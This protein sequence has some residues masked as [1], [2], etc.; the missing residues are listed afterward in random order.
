MSNIKDI[1]FASKNFVPAVK[2]EHHINDIGKLANYIPT[3]KSIDIIRNFCINENGSNVIIGSYG[4]GKSHLMALLAS[5]MCG[6]YEIEDY[7]ELVNKIGNIDEE[8]AELLVERMK[9]KRKRLIVIPSYNAENFEQAIL[10]G[11]SEALKREG[12]DYI[13][14]ENSFV[15]AKEEIVN[16]KNN[17]PET[18]DEF[19]N[20]IEKEYFIKKNKFMHGIESF[21]REYYKNFLNVYPRVTSG[22]QFVHYD[23]QNIVETIKQINKE[24]NIYGYDGL[25]IIFDE[26]G[27]FLEGNIDQVNMTEVQ[28]VAE[29]AND[30]ENNISLYLITH[31]DLS[32][33]GSK[34]SDRIVMEWRKVEGRFRRFTL[35]QNPVDIYQIISNTIIKDEKKFNGFYDCYKE[36]FSHMQD[37]IMSISTFKELSEDEIEKYLI[38]GCF[39]LAPLSVFA[40]CKLTDKIAQNNRTLFT[41]LVSNDENSFGDFIE[42]SEGQFWIGGDRIYDYFERS[43]WGENKESNIYDIWKEVN[44]AINKVGNNEVNIKIIKAIGLIYIIND[45]DKMKPNEKYISLLLP[46]YDIETIKNG[47]KELVEKKIIFYR[48]IYGIYKFYEGSDLNIQSY[49]NKLIDENREAI[50]IIDVLNK[51]FLPSPL[52]PRRYNDEYCINRYFECFFIRTKDLNAEKIKSDLEDNFKDGM[53][54]YLIP[55]DQDVKKVLNGM[56]K[57]NALSNLIIL[58][59]RKA[60]NIEERVL[61]YWVILQLLMDEEFLEKEEFLKEELILYEEEMSKEINTILS[62]TFNNEFKNVYVIHEGKVLLE[63]NNRYTLQ[64]EASKIMEKHFSKTPKINNEMINKNN[65]TSTM[66]SVERKV[67]NRLWESHKSG[68]KFKFKKFNAEYTTARTVYINTQ[69][70][71]NGANYKVNINYMNLPEAHPIRAIFYEI[72][73]FLKDCRKEETSFFELYKVLKNKPYGLKDGVI[74]L[75]FGVAICDNLDNIYIKRNEIYEDIDGKLLVEMVSNPRKF[76]VSIDVW[77]K[78]KENYISEIEN[79]FKENIDYEYRS[80]NR[81]GALYKGIKRYYMGLPKFTR[82]TNYISQQSKSIRNIISNDYMDYKKLFF[83]ILPG[84]NSYDLTVKEIKYAKNELD[85]FIENFKFEYSK[86]IVYVFGG[87]EKDFKASI[88]NWSRELGPKVRNHVFDLKTNLFIKYIEAPSEDYLEGLIKTLTGFD[89]EYLTDELADR[90]ISE[91]Q[92]IKEKMEG[93]SQSTNNGNFKENKIIIEVGG[94]KTIKGFD[95]VELNYLGKTL[96]NRIKR[97]IDNM[98]GAIKQE[99]IINILVDIFKNYI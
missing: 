77:D 28:E 86:R 13:P 23:S 42:N 15:K 41:F 61:K 49:V 87:E 89:L 59:P 31:K 22:A 82:E 95:D 24:M 45:F 99:E 71:E 47:I 93:Y 5:L 4:S 55:D 76:L 1:V 69:I 7:R 32:Q 21:D 39:P 14:I 60:L 81:L 62:T 18:Y 74:P 65:L 29:L 66:K 57:F 90:L 20:I 68:S 72:E 27:S 19:F 37:E 53:I 17:F 16:W 52:I 83:T 33:Y 10:I 40:L 48:K 97:D 94:N 54:Y 58:L 44:K 91:I 35:Y 36:K 73:E 12:Y 34:I 85:Q 11:I 9:E 56:N 43:I 98:G 80:K 25:D 30:I 63:V 2:V 38:K 3:E 8:T 64:K 75:L 84:D 88:E 96:K 78:E 50:D 70:L 51:Y 46:Q 6:N 67:I 92:D 26:F 79:I